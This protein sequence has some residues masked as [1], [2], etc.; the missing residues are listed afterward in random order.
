[1]ILLIILIA[2]A[3]ILYTI[4]A[5]LIKKRNAALEALSSID[6]QLKMRSDLIPNILTI[7]AKYMD[8]EKELLEQL[9]ALRARAD[10]PYDKNNA[11]AVTE[12][13][14]TASQLTT[15]MGK[16]QLTMEAYPTLKADAPLMEAQRSY[17]EVEA[18]IA[19][20][21]RGYNA[22]VTE[23][24]NAVQIFPGSAIAKAIDIGTMP[25]FATDEAS[26]APVNA[27]QYLN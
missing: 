13:L 21:R 5:G 19:A 24:N 3:F 15:Q 12:H 23:L 11:A 2:V 8:H 20:A 17:T 7:A 10:A 18:R 9:T 16:L 6:V 14:A 4:Y 1:M 22:S 25:F 27:A 26:K